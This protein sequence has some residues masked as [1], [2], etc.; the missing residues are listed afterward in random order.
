MREERP[1]MDDGEG[2]SQAT[3]HVEQPGHPQPDRRAADAPAPDPDH[4]RDAVRDGVQR[5]RR[6]R[7]LLAGGASVAVVLVLLVGVL[8]ITRQTDDQA[9]VGPDDGTMPLLGWRDGTYVVPGFRAGLEYGGTWRPPDG[10]GGEQPEDRERE[11]TLL[12]TRAGSEHEVRG[13]SEPTTAAGQ[14]ARLVHGPSEDQPDIPGWLVVAWE[15]EP[16]WYAAM[17]VGYEPDASGPLSTDEKLDL[18]TRAAKA[19]RP[20][21]PEMFGAAVDR[22]TR[23]EV[24]PTALIFASDDGRS[25]ARFVNGLAI[26]ALE[27]VPGGRHVTELCIGDVLEERRLSGPTVTVRGT[28]GVAVDV[29][30]GSSTATTGVP[31]DIGPD[32]VRTI[33]WS[34]GDVFY[35]LAVDG[36]VSIEDAVAIADAMHTPTAEEW[37]QLFVA[38]DPPRYGSDIYC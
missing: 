10:D 11:V 33:A 23:G 37:G 19:V 29:P 7:R 6:N 38:A 9:Y 36:S 30:P 8:A 22:A 24:A 34:E 1:A 32:G 35:R 25:V 21:D 5:R 27:P 31:P 17:F 4:G 3:G 18:L 20:I 26:I 14:P 12:V 13:R 28:E 15:P 16:G 2:D